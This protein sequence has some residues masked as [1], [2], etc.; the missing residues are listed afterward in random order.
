MPSENKIAEPLKV[1]RSTVT[2][3]VIT[4]ALR[5]EPVTG[6]EEWRDINETDQVLLIG[7]SVCR[8]R[9]KPWSAAN[10]A[11]IIELFQSLAA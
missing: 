2:K 11:D 4:G 3:L 6:A 9:R 10:A 8:M 7:N 5:L 1:E